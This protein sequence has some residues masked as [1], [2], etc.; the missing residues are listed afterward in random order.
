MSL[1]K[2]KKSK[3][4]DQD[5]HRLVGQI[6][7]DRLRVLK[8]SFVS[9]RQWLYE[10]EPPSVGKTRRA[11]KVLGHPEGREPGSFYRLSTSCDRMKQSTS[12]YLEKIYET[13]ILH[14]LSPYILVCTVLQ[15]FLFSP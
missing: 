11:L 15:Q 5:L 9:P 8:L 3:K 14:D 1:L 12:P 6:L 10:V 13:G 4:V 7:N 2:G